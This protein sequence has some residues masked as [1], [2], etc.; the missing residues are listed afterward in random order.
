[1]T[2]PHRNRATV[3][4][5]SPGFRSSAIRPD[6][7]PPPCAAASPATMLPPILRPSLPRQLADIAHQAM[8]DRDTREGM[9][10]FREIDRLAAGEPVG[11]LMQSV[12]TDPPLRHHAHIAGKTL[13]QR[14]LAQPRT[15]EMFR[16]GAPLPAK[17]SHKKPA[18]ARDSA[19][20]TT[21]HH[22]PDSRAK[23]IRYPG[24]TSKS[25]S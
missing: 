7:A 16:C 24:T 18:I 2:C 10:Q 6:V 22:S 14:A 20:S 8:P 13:L 25:S 5:T 3:R 15:L 17:D 4:L 1:M 11:G 21:P 9:S 23:W 12:S 19:S